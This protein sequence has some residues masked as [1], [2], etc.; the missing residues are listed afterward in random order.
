[1]TAPDRGDH[2]ASATRSAWTA[3]CCDGSLMQRTI[4]AGSIADT[5][6]LRAAADQVAPTRW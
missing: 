2:A 5:Y 6:R 4:S 1:M 3:A